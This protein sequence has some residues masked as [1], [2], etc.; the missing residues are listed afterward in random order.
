MK[1]KIFIFNIKNYRCKM[2]FINE[3]LIKL[4]KQLLELEHQVKEVKKQLEAF[5][6][7]SATLGMVK[8]YV[9]KQQEQKE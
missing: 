5:H 7:E 6:M 4:I 3:D 9:K 8:K 2:E 1:F